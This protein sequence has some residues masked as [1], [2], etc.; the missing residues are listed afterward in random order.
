MESTTAEASTVKAAAASEA[1]AAVATTATS[2]ST[3]TR[4]G[5]C[6]RYQA[7][8]RNRRQCDNRFTQH[9][10]SPSVISLPTT[11]SAASGDRFG[12]LPAKFAQLHAIRILNLVSESSV[13]CELR[14]RRDQQKSPVDKNLPLKRIRD[15]PVAASRGGDCARNGMGGLRL[16]PS[17][18][19][20]RAL[21]CSVSAVESRI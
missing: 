11:T 7:K 21:R 5:H 13:V 8:G 4:Q 6:W 16:A 18:N 20:M 19:R 1:S 9:S 17:F 10:H 12:E 3:A 15:L 2:T 14:A